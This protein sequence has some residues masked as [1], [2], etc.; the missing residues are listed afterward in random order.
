VYRS[1]YHNA[2]DSALEAVVFPAP[3]G[4]SSPSTVEFP[5]AASPRHGRRPVMGV[6]AILRV[7]FFAMLVD[8]PRAAIHAV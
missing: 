2:I 4:L 1:L 3:A 8:I 7:G 5:T 6:L